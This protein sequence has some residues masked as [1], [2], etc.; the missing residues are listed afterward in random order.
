MK[1]PKLLLV[2]LL[3]LIACEDEATGPLSDEEK[4][5]IWEEQQAIYDSTKAA[6]LEA[7][8]DS[9]KSTGGID[10]QCYWFDNAEVSEECG[11][12]DD[13]CIWQHF[14]DNSD[15]DSDYQCEASG[16]T[17]ST[18]FGSSVGQVY[19]VRSSKAYSYDFLNGESRTLIDEDSLKHISTS[20]STFPYSLILE[21]DA[22]AGFKKVEN[23]KFS[24]ADELHAQHVLTGFDSLLYYAYIVGD[25]DRAD[26]FASVE[27]TESL[28]VGDLYHVTHADEEDGYAFVTVM[29][30]VEINTGS[31]YEDN[32]IG[33]K[34]K[35]IGIKGEVIEQITDKYFDSNN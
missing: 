4:Q 9:I 23:L 17:Q 30:I 34:Y 7:A 1:F 25:F 3:L 33:F 16:L 10:P 11:V 26:D 21:S 20:S 5:L 15:I 28:E 2:P 12:E 24:D 31:D 19:D 8:V 14:V 35:N 13:D 6:E 22:G 18:S 32:F 27:E 29:E